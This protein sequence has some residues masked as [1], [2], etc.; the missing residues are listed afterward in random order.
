[1]KFLFVLFMVLLSC[2]SVYSDKLYLENYFNGSRYEI[3]EDAISSVP[4]DIYYVVFYQEQTICYTK[5]DR[6]APSYLAFLK[7]AKGGSPFN[8]QVLAKVYCGSHYRDKIVDALK[9]CRS[10]R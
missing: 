2:S 8:I 6:K 10:L 7:V 5:S 1:M 3:A 4:N 9:V